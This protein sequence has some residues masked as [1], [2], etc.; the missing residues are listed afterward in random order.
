MVTLRDSNN[1]FC[2]AEYGNA[3]EKGAFLN[4]YE[5]EELL[6]ITVDSFSTIPFYYVVINNKLYGSTK[7]ELLL[8]S[9]PK[10]FIVKLNILS[11]IVFLRTNSL[12]GNS[13]LISGIE[14]IPYGHELVFDKRN[15]NA[16][17][18]K[19]WELPG[20]VED[21]DENNL[22]E[23]LRERFLAVVE[24][25]IKSSDSIGMH[26]SGGMDSRQIFG[27]LI[28]TKRKFK[29]FTY[30]IEENLDVG[31]AKKIAQKFGIEQHYIKWEGVN[32]FKTYFD[33]IF[34]MTD[35]MQAIF[36]GHGLDAY[37]VEK[38]K[39][40]TILYGH[41]ID[42]Y[43]QGHMYNPKYEKELGPFTNQLLYECFDGGPC[44]V[45]RGDSIEP[46]MLTKECS[47]LF[48]ES[49]YKELAKFDYM[50]PEKRYDAMYFVHHGLRRLLPQ[51]QA[52]A[53]FLDFRVPGLHRDFFDISWSIP[54][55]LR[56]HRGLQE[57]L[58]RRINSEMMRVPVVKDNAEILYMGKNRLLRCTS[59]IMSRMKKEGR[60]P[61][62]PYF[63]YYGVGIREHANH[64]LFNW[65]KDEIYKSGILD[66]GFLKSDYISSI[67]SEGRF[68][69][70]ISL[71][72]YGALMTLARF[73]N[74]YCRG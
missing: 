53:H 73:Y 6:K 63:D 46:S 74:Q 58:L 42:F 30:G 71:G 65:I 27:A 44:S 12:I 21:F 39:V 24:E 62:K 72:H 40:D 29:C 47:G 67:F 33:K 18:V 51:V 54:G 69:P 49:I 56:K 38:D 28:Q 48:R 4:I 60:W 10:D 26:L 64:D 19:Y 9:L 37:E 3:P 15:G 55:K 70:H 20:N 17:L 61:F 34:S 31:V 35:G 57:K 32:Y 68:H 45:M 7:I 1:N 8:E 22:V 16:K 14:R 43:I 36:H 50:V 2:Y 23:T 25:S 11:A 41:F 66:A 52:G 5:N 59:R 13:T